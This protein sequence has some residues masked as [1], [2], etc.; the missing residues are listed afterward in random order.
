[1]MDF[2][3]AFGAAQDEVVI[4]CPIKFLPKSPCQGHHRFLH[5]EKVGDVV[6]GAQQIQ[7]KVRL[8]VGL[9]VFGQV[10]GYFVLIC[11]YAVNL[12]V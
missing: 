5:Q 10:C 7:V 4:L 9:E 8:Q 3:C 2:L 11:V 1:M 12:R 6:V